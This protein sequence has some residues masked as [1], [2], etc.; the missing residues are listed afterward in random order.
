MCRT[1]VGRV[2]AVED[3]AAVVELDGWNRRALSLLVPD[4]RPG[5]L[6]LVGLGTILGRVEPADQAALDNIRNGA[7]ASLPSHPQQESIT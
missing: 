1:A 3:G 5:D 6:V 4:V 2:I 7:V